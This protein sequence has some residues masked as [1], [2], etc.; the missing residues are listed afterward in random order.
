M[1]LDRDAALSFEATKPKEIPMLRKTSFSAVAVFVVLGALVLPATTANA[2]TVT[3]A[4]L[5]GGLLSVDGTNAAPLIFVTVRSSTSFAGVRSD[6]SGEYHVQRANFRA[7]N[8]QVVVSDRHTLDATVTL[9][10]CTP[11]AP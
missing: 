2:I 1:A 10:G 9:S 8:C 7:D 5:R 6:G 11:T 3:R 4:T